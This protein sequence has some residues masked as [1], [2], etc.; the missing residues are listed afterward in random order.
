MHLK[1]LYKRKAESALEIQC[2]CMNQEVVEADN[3]ALFT[4][5]RMQEGENIICSGNI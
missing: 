1:Y 5:K 2:S 3:S 4:F